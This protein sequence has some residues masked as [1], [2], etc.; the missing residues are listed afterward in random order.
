MTASLSQAAG[1][2]RTWLFEAMLPLWTTAGFDERTGQFVEALSPQ[3]EPLPLNRR[4]LVQAR[5]MVVC[6]AGGRLGWSGPWAERAAAAGETLLARGRGGSGDWIYSFDSDGRPADARGDLY[7]QAFVIL[8]FAEAGRALGRDDFLDAARTTCARLETSWADP[9]GGFSEGE[10]APHPGRQNPHMH[11]L[12]AFLALHAATGEAADLARAE[13]LGALFMSRLLLG[14]ETIPE[15]FDS[16]WRPIAAAGAAPGH[17][18]EWAF[19]L[20]RLRQAGGEDRSRTAKALADRGEARGV[21]DAGFT[22]DLMSWNG[23]VTVPSARLWPQA[24]RLR[25]AAAR[26]HDDP[27]ATAAALQARAALF[28][29][30]EAP[31]PGGWRDLR[32]AGGRWADGPAPASSAYHITGAL[33][34]LI[35][36]GEPY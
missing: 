8:G 27:G 20:D 35:A 21:D 2:A 31:K 25:A 7:S 28:A 12:E 29:F 1:E 11:I 3:G 6:C 13:R 10:I 24:E 26:R 30:L 4:T 33:E 5:Q 34:A 36:A 14:S 18:F 9:T 22:V 17:Q 32:L 15:E 19:L 23:V 16:S